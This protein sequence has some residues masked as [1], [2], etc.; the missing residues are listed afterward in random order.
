MRLEAEIL[1]QL[2]RRLGSPHAGER[3]RRESANEKRM[4]RDGIPSLWAY[5]QRFA[6]TL[7]RAA[8]K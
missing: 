6:P 7:I 2:D 1:R 3:L 8:L 5:N 4:A